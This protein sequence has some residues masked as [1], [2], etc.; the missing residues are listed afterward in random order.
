MMAKEVTF[1]GGILNINNALPVLRKTIHIHDSHEI[2]EDAKALDK[3][4]TYLC[5]HASNHDEAMYVKFVEA[6]LLNTKS[7]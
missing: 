4:E 6:L 3:H 1:A 7:T 2:R 5:E